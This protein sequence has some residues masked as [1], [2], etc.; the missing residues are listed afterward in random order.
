[1][2]DIPP[3]KL[4]PELSQTVWSGLFTMALAWLGRLMWH[5]RE[6]QG[7]RRKF[8]SVH[9]VWELL[10]AC[11]IGL[12][13]DGLAEYLGLSGRPA[14][15]VVIFIAYLGPRGVEEILLKYA[16]KF[17]TKKPK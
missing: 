10:T 16:D 8:F 17:A 7:Q 11:C 13:A 14:T 15:A 12:M 3:P 5:V 6:V 4:P 9:L 2:F 1:M